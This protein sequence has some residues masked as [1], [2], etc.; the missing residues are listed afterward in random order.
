V[1]LTCDSIITKNAC[2][3]TGNGYRVANIKAK[4]LKSSDTF[5]LIWHGGGTAFNYMGVSLIVDEAIGTGGDDENLAYRFG[6]YGNIDIVGQ[7]T[8]IQIGQGTGVN[9]YEGTCNHL[10][11]CFHLDVKAMDASAVYNGSHVSK[12]DMEG[13]GII[14][15]NWIITQG[16]N[17][18]NDYIKQSSGKALVN[19]LGYQNY[20]N[21]I[22]I[23]GGTFIGDGCWYSRYPLKEIKVSGGTFIWK[24]KYDAYVNSSATYGSMRHVIEQTGGTVKIQGTIN[25]AGVFSSA[26]P[27]KIVKYNGGKLIL[28]GATLTTVNDAQGN[29]TPAIFPNANRDVHIF[30]GGVNYNQTGS[31]ALL[32]ASG[33][34]FELTNILGGMIIED[35]DVE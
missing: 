33:S 7:A 10:G 34:G 29:P 11:R 13:D 4:L 20:S 18:F 31:N 22:E 16:G 9:A 15:I 3:S 30:S 27:S 1:H 28:D 8:G 19:I 26:L 5:A 17:T 35:A 25:F 32:A 2:I 14:N 12:V 6:S 21:E 24:G 23:T